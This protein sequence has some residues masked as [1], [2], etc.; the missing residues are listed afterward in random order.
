VTY[1]DENLF[2]TIVNHSAHWILESKSLYNPYSGITNNVAESL[3]A[4]LKRLLEQP[5]RN[6]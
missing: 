3:N 5:E 2:S 4:K 6:G 1:F